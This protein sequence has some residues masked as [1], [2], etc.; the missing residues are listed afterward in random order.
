MTEQVTSEDT[1]YP[2]STGQMYFIATDPEN[3]YRQ[4][5]TYNFRNSTRFGKVTSVP[6]NSDDIDDINE[7]TDLLEDKTQ[8]GPNLDIGSGEY[9]AFAY[10]SRLGNL[11]TYN[12]RF[13]GMTVGMD[14]VTVLYENEIGYEENYYVYISDIDNLGTSSFYTNGT[15]I[16][17][18]IKYGYGSDPA[19]WD[20]AF[21][22][23]IQY[24]EIS[25][26]DTQS[27]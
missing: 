8:A 21:I 12:F 11:S 25:S 15:S 19:S 10:P 18:E 16:L 20:E 9:I 2:S 3:N 4:S 1:N 13:G 6:A 5:G 7:E 22:N 23:T 27:G 24:N 26:N 14:L 17:N